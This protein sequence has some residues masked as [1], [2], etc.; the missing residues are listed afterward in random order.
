MTTR[1]NVKTTAHRVVVSTSAQ[2]FAKVVHLGLNLVSTLAIV[3]YLTP[4]SYG[5]YILVMTVTALV[6]LIAD[7]GLGSLAVR[8]ITAARVEEGQIV[9]TVVVL[10]LVL[11]LSAM[12]AAQLVLALMHQSQLVHV[13]AAVASAVCLAD[14]ALGAVVVVFQVRI[15]QHY[16]AFIRIVMEAIE[17]A[18]ILL[19]VSRRADLPLLVAP[20]VL[21]AV[22]GATLAFG[23]ARHRYALRP[24]FEAGQLRR[25]LT[26]ALPI[27]PALFLGVVYLKLDNLVLAAMRPKREV[28]LYGSAYQPI[29]YMFLAAAVV[30]G[31][32]FPLLSAA[33]GRADHEAF[34]RLYRR[35]TEVLVIAAL[36]VPVVMLF[37][38]RPLVTLVF[39]EAYADAAG[40][41]QLLSVV[42]VLMTVNGWQSIVLLAGGLQSVT[43]KY[44]AV[45][46]GVSLC[47]CV[48]CVALFG[49][50]GAAFAALGTASFVLY[51]STAAIRRHLGATL[52][53]QRLAKIG[54]AGAI[55]VGFSAGLQ[56]VGAP[57][58]LIGLFAVVPYFGSLLV[59]GLHRQFHEA[60]A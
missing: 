24:R 28:G 52:D 32:V 3:R 55:T 56:A 30:V 48:I 49:L 16:E 10:R 53:L 12:G 41:L 46:L 5:I 17:T 27:G 58:L 4:D 22:V 39:G 11:G 9:G 37:L 51:S 2:L 8:E 31:V 42:L 18:V 38:A 50:M 23:V 33:H 60:T 35:G 7:F 6:G 59:F 44:N 47:L 13:A 36:G 15:M 20:P 19:L 14:A 29:E 25:L 43:L 1:R 34:V 26:Q 45:A 57:W 40:P 21:G 54:L